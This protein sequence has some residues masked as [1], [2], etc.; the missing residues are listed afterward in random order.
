MENKSRIDKNMPDNNIE[1]L[2]ENNKDKR[3][4]LSFWS[5]MTYDEFVKVKEY[6]NQTGNLK[7][8]KFLIPPIDF[9]IINDNELKRIKLSY[10]SK[11]DSTYYEKHDEVIKKYQKDGLNEIIETLDKKYQ[12]FDREDYVSSIKTKMSF[13]VKIEKEDKNSSEPIR[14]KI[15]ESSSLYNIVHNYKSI[16]WKDT[17]RV[18]NLE[19][20]ITG[21]LKKSIAFYLSISY[22]LFNDFTL[23]IEKE[24]IEQK[25]EIERLNKEVEQIE[26]ETEKSKE[27]L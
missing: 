26:M 16:F 21:E 10:T 1:Q 7:N 25:K 23:D 19:Y 2:I 20:K 3:L 17:N 24:L 27:K 12:R 4:F 22:T 11:D 14:F 18:I 8:D 13:P 5:G 15:S 9:E 6:E